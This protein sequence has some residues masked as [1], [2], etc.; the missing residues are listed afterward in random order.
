MSEAECCIVQIETAEAPLL[1]TF[2]VIE[3]VAQDALRVRTDG[4]N[5]GIN[6]H[7]LHT[8]LVMTSYYV[9]Y[10]TVGQVVVES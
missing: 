2:D 9:T 6:E 7:V 4:E 10:C 8:V 1:D 3:H 5:C